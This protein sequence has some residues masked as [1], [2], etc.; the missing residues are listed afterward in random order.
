MGTS[1]VSRRAPS[2]SPTRSRTD[3]Q[4]GIPSSALRPV[5]APR[6]NAKS[7]PKTALNVEFWPQNQPDQAAGGTW[8][9][10]VTEM[11]KDGMA[12]TL[13]G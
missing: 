9:L 10:T 3:L 7:G 2:R 4:L 5:F 13:G 8:P 12:D 6:R 1:H 11:N